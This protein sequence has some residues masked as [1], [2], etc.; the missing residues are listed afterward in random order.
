MPFW[1]MIRWSWRVGELCRGYKK[2][3]QILRR[4]RSCQT[5]RQ[6][7]PAFSH[8]SPK[9]GGHRAIAAASEPDAR[10]KLTRKVRS[11]KSGVREIAEVLR[12]RKGRR[13]GRTG[14]QVATYLL[15]L[16]EC[17]VINARLLEV[18][19]RG[20]DHLVDD[21]LVHGALVVAVSKPAFT[22]PPLACAPWGY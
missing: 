5:D 18:I 15:H 17:G 19:L 12:Q 9:P 10:N 20:R 21:L 14:G 4:P 13:A 8:P 1:E 6:L 2:T 11:L 7:R 3:S 16:V 22:L